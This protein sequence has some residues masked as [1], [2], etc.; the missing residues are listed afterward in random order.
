LLF[1]CNHYTVIIV[2]AVFAI[3]LCCYWL[4]Y[5]NNIFILDR[6]YFLTTHA[7]THATINALPEFNQLLDFFN[8][9]DSRLILTLVYDS[10]NLAINPFISGC[11]GKVP[12]SREC[13]RSW[14]VLHAQWTC[15][16]GFLFC[17]V[18]Q[19]H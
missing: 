10:L 4:L 16:L 13:C 2:A 1:G 8:L 17:K 19:K 5:Y 15:L 18:M 12:Q 11:W 9:F 14:T 3:L 7:Y 6:A